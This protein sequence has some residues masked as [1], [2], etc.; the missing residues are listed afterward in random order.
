MVMCQALVAFA[1]MSVAKV[2]ATAYT[3]QLNGLWVS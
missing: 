2:M 3:Y 1:E